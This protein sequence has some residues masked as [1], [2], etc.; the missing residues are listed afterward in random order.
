MSKLI[1]MTGQTVGNWK[2]IRRGP[3]TKNGRAQWEC[4]CLLCNKTIKF[5][6]PASSGGVT[7]MLLFAL[8]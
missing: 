1:D 5:T 2:V 7:G 4:K 3:N 8:Y 6:P